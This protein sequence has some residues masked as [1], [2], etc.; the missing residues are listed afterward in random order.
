MGKGRKERLTPLT[1]RVAAVLKAWLPALPKDS[2]R[3]FPNAR[4]HPLSA[5]AVQRLLAKYQRK[6]CRTCPSLTQKHLTPHVLR[7][8][9]AMRLLQAGIDQSVIA[10]WLGHESVQTTQI[11]LE[12]DLALKEQALSKTVHAGGSCPLFKPEDPLL[13][14]LK[15][16]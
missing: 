16:L 8:T 11:Y 4:G 9:A 10:L 2:Q 5:D 1:K 7:H 13:A 6:A 15:T 14:L 12:A 3:L